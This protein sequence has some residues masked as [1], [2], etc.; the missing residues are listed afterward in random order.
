MAPEL[1]DENYNEKVDIYAFGMLLLEIITRDVPY[2]ECANPAQIYKKVTQGIPP[3]SLNRV[4]SADARNFIL[5]CLGIGE[6]ANA[7]PSASDLL[8]HQFLAKNSD[9]ETTIELE[10]AVEDMIIEEAAQTRMTFSDDSGSEADVPKVGGNDEKATKNTSSIPGQVAGSISP[11]EHPE[12]APRNENA[13]ALA[14]KGS[15]PLESEDLTRSAGKMDDE[16]M[17]DQF[18]EMPENEANMKKVTVLMGRGTALSDDE[19]PAKEMEVISLSSTPPPAALIISPNPPPNIVMDAETSKLGSSLPYKVWAVPPPVIDGGNKP[20]PN[21]AINLALTLPDVSQTTIEF[22]FDLVDDDPVQ[23]AREMVTELDEVPDDAVLEISTAISAVAREARMKQNQW[24]QL[25]Q[26]QQQNVLAQQAL[27]QQ[28]QQ[29]SQSMMALH[30]PG[31]VS[32]QPQPIQAPQGMVMPTHQHHMYGSG[33]PSS[34]SFQRTGGSVVEP[35][36]G[37]L[38]NDVSQAAVSGPLSNPLQSQQRAQHHVV[39][40]PPPP[41]EPSQS[42][43]PPSSQMSTLHMSVPQPQHQ[44]P[45]VRQSVSRPSSPSPLSQLAHETMHV[46]RC[47]EPTVNRSSSMDL[48]SLSVQ[49]ISNPS[50]SQTPTPPGVTQQ[51][52]HLLTPALSNASQDVIVS[53]QVAPQAV[54]VTQDASSKV[55]HKGHNTALQGGAHNSQPSDGTEDENDVDAD[56]EEIRKLELEFEKKL[57]RAKKSYHTRMDNLHRSKEEVE[58]QHQMLLEKHEKERI[59]FDKRVRLAEEEQARRL[60]QI[61]KEFIEKKKEVQQQRAKLPPTSIAPMQQTQN[62]SDGKGVSGS[63]PPLHGGHKR[64]SSH[65][66]SSM[67]H[68]PTNV[69]HRK[70][71]SES[72]AAESSPTQVDPQQQQHQPP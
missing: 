53:R 10:P 4:K 3:P 16:Q 36:P 11:S 57:Q 59:E 19:P 29:H 45:D 26:Q 25:Q 50:A 60:N 31:S 68:T 48:L 46:R 70:N 71:I 56:A 67:A 17:D 32:M 51:Q 47:T 23:V 5:L 54:S 65:F 35:Q 43:T 28:H 62:G 13:V 41:P 69:E 44:M 55:L 9:D 24:T 18:G 30:S 39:P 15:N 22:T 21:N 64:S 42:F 1:Y 72:N 63:R 8:K 49:P 38:G 7:R 66:D 33:F 58:A 37:P 20:Y 12:K 40:I 6:D 61:Q 2:H 14:N 34:G 27:H 52:Q